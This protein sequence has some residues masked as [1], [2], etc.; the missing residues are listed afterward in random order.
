MLT[1][2]YGAGHARTDCAVI[3]IRYKDISTGTDQATWLHGRTEDDARGVI[4]YLVPGL[5]SGQ[6]RAVIRRLRQE[7]SRGFGPALPLPQLTIGLALDRV[8]TAARIAAAII[9]LHPAVTLLPSAL[10]AGVLTLLVLA[11]ASGPGLTPGLPGGIAQAAVDGSVQPVGPGPA[12]ARMTS[13][14]AAS[15]AKDNAMAASL[16]HPAQRNAILPGHARLALRGSAGYVCFVG[17]AVSVG[18][19]QPGQPVHPCSSS[20][21]P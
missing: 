2:A 21:A 19:P 9:R 18:V 4:V 10:V 16:G 8:R 13:A 6:R 3:R 1:H 12:L 14:L 20:R 15:A 11:S 5:T 7:A 17:V